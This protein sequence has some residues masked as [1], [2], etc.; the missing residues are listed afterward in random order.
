MST[1]DNGLLYWSTPTATF[2][3]VVRNGVVVTSPPYARK[4]A[5]GRRAEDLVAG[6]AANVTMVWIPGTDAVTEMPHLPLF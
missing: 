1:M 5:Q 6:A 3:L 4:W 2:G